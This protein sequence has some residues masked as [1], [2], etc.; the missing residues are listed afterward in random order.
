LK[1][2]G[3]GKWQYVREDSLVPVID[4]FFASRIFGPKRLAHFRAHG[5]SLATE[6]VV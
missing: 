3:H 2:L 4:S 1:V 5:P 6:L